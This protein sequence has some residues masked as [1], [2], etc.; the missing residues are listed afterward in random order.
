MKKTVAVLG[1]GATGSILSAYLS[2]TQVN[3]VLKAKNERLLQLEKDGINVVGF[4]KISSK[5]FTLIDSVEQLK[6][7]KIDALFI[8]TKTT[9][10]NSLLPRLK[11]NIS[12]ETLLISFQNGI[13]T[14]DEIEKYYPNNPIARFV[15]NFAGNMIHDTGAVCMTW[16][17]PP[18][19][20]GPHTNCSSFDLSWIV[21]LLNESELS[22]QLVTKE[23]MKSS[24]FIKTALN[25]TLNPYCS[26]SNLTMSEAMR[27]PSR[28]IVCQILKENLSVGKALGYD[29][30]EKS[31]EKY[32][33]NYL[34]KGGN[35]YPSMWG[36]IHH[37]RQTEIDFI[38]GQILD[39]AYRLKL[40]LPMNQLITTMVIASE[41]KN[42][43]RN[44]ESMPSYL[45]KTCF[46]ECGSHTNAS[47]ERKS[48]LKELYPVSTHHQ[49]T[50]K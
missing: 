26:I 13:G 15:I 19:I 50:K 21:D 4:T 10:F 2:K 49:C 39:M 31:I 20:I 48:C 33:L 24:A 41:I 47:E 37:K 3:L 1:V 5:N 9:T 45:F 6:N 8:C 38:N 22:T 16:F 11:N 28:T 17:H 44:E 43:V 25:A 42:G 40:D 46:H 7:S 32:L 34:A 36:D 29:I 27:T 23:E 18:N 30:D 12:P 14:E 35:H